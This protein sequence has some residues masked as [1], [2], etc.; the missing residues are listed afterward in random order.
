MTKPKRWE[1][2]TSKIPIKSINKE[3]NK[4]ADALHDDG[5]RI[6]ERVERGSVVDDEWVEKNTQA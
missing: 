5:V 1:G 4:C 6:L 2:R 3:I